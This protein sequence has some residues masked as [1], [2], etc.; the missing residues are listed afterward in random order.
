MRN[1]WDNFVSNTDVLVF[2][3]DS[4]DVDRFTEAKDELHKLLQDD[5]LKNVP[6][7][8]VANKQVCLYSLCRYFIML[9]SVKDL[10]TLLFMK[11][12]HAGFYGSSYIVQVRS[13]VSVVGRTNKMA[14]G[15][16]ARLR[17]LGLWFGF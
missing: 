10:G 13:H 17:A 15:P 9:T 2:V 1:Y 7:V 6:L 14:W 5:R 4:A 11:S 12:F 16:G 8:L 3:V